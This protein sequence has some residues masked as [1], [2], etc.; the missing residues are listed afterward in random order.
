MEIFKHK[1]DK[2]DSYEYRRLITVFEEDSLNMID[3]EHLLI[4]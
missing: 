1:K 3:N 4:D 2:T